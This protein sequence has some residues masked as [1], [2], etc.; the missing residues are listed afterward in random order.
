MLK[1]FSYNCIWISFSCFNIYNLNIEHIKLC[2][3]ADIH[4]QLS[5]MSR[6]PIIP[7]VLFS[8]MKRHTASCI[9]NFFQ[10]ATPDL[11]SGETKP[12]LFGPQH[13]HI[14]SW[15]GVTFDPNNTLASI[16]HYYDMLWPE[17]LLNWFQDFRSFYLLFLSLSNSLHV[18]VLKHL[19]KNK[20]Q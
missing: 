19:Q 7:I 10:P 11:C 12:D 1:I 16:N 17:L 4:F 15:Q 5:F 8:A 18:Y 3:K 6:T 14:C 20:I 9:I 13:S 2:L